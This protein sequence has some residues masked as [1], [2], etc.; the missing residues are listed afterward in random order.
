MSFC[1][2][3]WKPCNLF[4][5][6]IYFGFINSSYLRWCQGVVQLIIISISTQF[7]LRNRRVDQAFNEQKQN[8]T[9][10]RPLTACAFWSNGN[11]ARSARDPR[12]HGS[13][14]EP[15]K[16]FGVSKTLGSDFID[17]NDCFYSYNNN[18]NK[19][20]RG[21]AV[22]KW[23]SDQKVPSHPNRG[24]NLEHNRGHK[25]LKRSDKCKCTKH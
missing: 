20:P 5:S 1:L 18:N 22:C 23:W 12:G 24:H 9:S 16:R 10:E 14:T 8:V 2:K 4:K 17:P 21:G 19:M 3:V 25:A 13:A 15:R 6:A 11:L 7:Q